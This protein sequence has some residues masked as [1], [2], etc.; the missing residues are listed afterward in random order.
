MS[1]VHRARRRHAGVVWSL[2]LVVLVAVFGAWE[3]LATYVIDPFYYSKPSLI[4]VRLFEWFTVGTSKGSIWS[5]IS[6]TLQEAVYGFVLG[7][8]LGVILGILLGRARLLAEVLQPF[9]QALN[10][11]PRIVLAALFIIWF[12]LGMESKVATALVLVFFPVFFNAFQGAREVDRN[13]VD[14]ARILGASRVQILWSIVVPSATS[15]ILASLHTA[16]GFAL[17][18]AIVGEYAG[19][20]KGIGLLIS[21]AQGT[22]DSAGIYAGMILSTVLALLA[23]VILGGAEKR[24]LRWRPPSQATTTAGI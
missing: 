23:E 16:F 21:T 5:N 13:F 6:V 17:I 22:F 11:V 1:A 24:L 19:A 15:W 14:N 7:A 10:A 20:S 2:R 18:G 4:V 3:V 9:I 12:G 8:I